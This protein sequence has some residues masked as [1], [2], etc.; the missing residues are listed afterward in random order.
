MRFREVKFK[1]E[2]TLTEIGEIVAD[3]AIK[4]L[5]IPR[6]EIEVGEV[7]ALDADKDELYQLDIITIAMTKTADGPVW[8]IEPA[9]NEPAA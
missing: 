4:E 5:G 1:V 3:H 9:R 2:Y 7:Q 6:H 8:I